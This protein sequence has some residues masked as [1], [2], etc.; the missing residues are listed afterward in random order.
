MNST[1]LEQAMGGSRA[2]LGRLISQLEAEGVEAARIIDQLP[3]FNPGYTIAITGAP[4]AGKST[5][6]NALISG[7]NNLIK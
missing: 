7:S 4:G 3:A 1:K 2:A 6:T 5:L